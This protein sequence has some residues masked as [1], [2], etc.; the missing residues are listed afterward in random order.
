MSFLKSLNA[1][2]VSSYPYDTYSD[3]P[4]TSFPEGDDYPE[5]GVYWAHPV[6]PD[7]PDQALYDA[8]ESVPVFNESLNRWEQSWVISDKP[9]PFVVPNWTGFYDG[10]IMSSTYNHLL[11]LTVPYPSISG[12]MA[13]MG[14]AILQGQSDPS[15]P[16]RLAALQAAV[17]AILSVLN[18]LEIPLTSEQL[19]EVR[20]LLDANGFNEI[21]LG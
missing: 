12:V 2:I 10:L 14:V 20:V 17:S 4:N 19:T 11:G 21:T 3:Y 18:A 15:N 13:V 1:G 8:A 6:V 16:S 5:F 7:N 9:L